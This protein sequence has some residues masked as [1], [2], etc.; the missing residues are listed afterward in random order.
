[1][2]QKHAWDD[3]RSRW[4][5]ADH[6]H[7]VPRSYP[8]HNSS[9]TSLT[10]MHE[11]L[12]AWST[13]AHVTI[14]KE[15]FRFIKIRART[16]G[17]TRMCWIDTATYDHA[18]RSHHFFPSYTDCSKLKHFSA[19]MYNPTSP[20]NSGC[21]QIFITNGALWE[22]LAH[23]TWHFVHTIEG[24]D[25]VTCGGQ[26]ITHMSA[27]HV[28]IISPPKNHTSTLLLVIKMVLTTCGCAIH[29]QIQYTKAWRKD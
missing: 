11:V 12:F 9:T 10:S 27:M 21:M 18:P 14:I 23:C 22:K 20:N 24:L 6:P 29:R 3:L 8:R 1:M 17:I 26:I 5:S 16:I 2:C 15:A 28:M 25:F 4:Q 7:R 13:V 19:G